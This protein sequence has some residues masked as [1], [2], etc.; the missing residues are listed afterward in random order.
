MIGYFLKREGVTNNI[1]G[2]RYP[3]FFI[4]FCNSRLIVYA[5]TG[6]SPV[7]KFLD[8][9][10]VY[11]PFLFQHLKDVCAKNILKEF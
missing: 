11:F 6:M 8:Y 4:I 10:I 5:E 9:V 1:L 2:K 7:H 3:S